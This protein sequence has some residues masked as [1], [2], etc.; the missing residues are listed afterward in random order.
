M[1]IYV[2]ESIHESLNK[3][4][5]TCKVLLCVQAVE[6]EHIMKKYEEVTARLEQ[7]LEGI[8]FEKLDISD[9]VK[10]QV[11]FFLISLIYTKM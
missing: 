9:E 8:C 6:K 5:L 4:G 10:E 1:S 3:E 11:K 2:N 7:D